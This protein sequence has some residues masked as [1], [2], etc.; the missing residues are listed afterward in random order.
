VHVSISRDQDANI[1]TDV[2]YQL[3][4]EH[5]DLA[6][7]HMAN[8][9]E[10]L[11]RQFLGILKSVVSELSPDDLVSWAHHLHDR[12]QVVE[13]LA[14][15]ATETRW[16][17]LNAALLLRL[18]N[19]MINRGIQFNM[20]QVQEITVLTHPSSINGQTGPVGT[21]ILRGQPAQPTQPPF[22]PSSTLLSQQPTQVFTVPASATAPAAQY[23][24]VVLPSLEPN[25][26][27]PPTQGVVQGMIDAY[28]AINNQFINDPNFIMDLAARFKAVANN[29]L[30]NANFP[31]DAEKAAFNLI[32]RANYILASEERRHHSSQAPTQTTVVHHV[33]HV[34]NPPNEHLTKGG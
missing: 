18:R 11:H 26:S 12:Q 3:D 27:A 6:V 16:D 28:Y 29:P 34:P 5:A 25:L 19:Q 8:W 22:N 21:G 15:P 32:Q 33:Y 7:L 30:A 4:E 1:V 17:R 2:T 9:E 24:G 31:V 14:N 13:D 23:S 20:V 10:E